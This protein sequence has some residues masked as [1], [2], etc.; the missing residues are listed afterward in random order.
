MTLTTSLL[1]QAVFYAF[2]SVWPNPTLQPTRYGVLPLAAGHA[3][4][5]F[6]PGRSWHH[7]SAGG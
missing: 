1:K 2:G 4:R 7:T 6:S 3:L 5:A